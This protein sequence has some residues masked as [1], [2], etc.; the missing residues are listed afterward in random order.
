MAAAASKF[1]R[2]G[3][4]D[5]KGDCAF[6]ALSEFP[7][8]HMSCLSTITFT[9]AAR[10]DFGFALSV[11]YRRVQGGQGTLQQTSVY[12]RVP[13]IHAKSTRFLP[14]PA[15][16]KKVNKTLLQNPGVTCHSVCHSNSFSGRLWV[17]KLEV[18]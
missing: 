6:R 2:K 7:I 3:E 1:G 9:A 15:N 16:P 4:I 8:V 10:I 5:E 13:P 17:V 18:C 12:L 11:L 14:S